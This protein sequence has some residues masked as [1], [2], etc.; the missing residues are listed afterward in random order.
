MEINIRKARKEDLPAMLVMIKEL[1]EYERAPNE[2]DVTINKFEKYFDKK[3]FKALV[4]YHNETLVG[5]AIFYI[6]YSTWKGK[7]VYLDDLIVTETMRGKSVGTKLFK[8]VIRT[9]YKLKANQLRWHVLE[10]NTPAI[11]FY[12]KF[13]A[14]LDPEWITG[15]LSKQQMEQYI[16]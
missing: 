14:G 16:S 1:A 12:E 8:E 13:E 10:W 9:S 7:I 3:F 2:V 6:A 5:M 4:A 11:N 15:K